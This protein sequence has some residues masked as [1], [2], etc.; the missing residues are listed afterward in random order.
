[1]NKLSTKNYKKGEILISPFLFI[2]CKV[3]LLLIK[4]LIQKAAFT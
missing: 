2:L 1:L 3:E 4:K